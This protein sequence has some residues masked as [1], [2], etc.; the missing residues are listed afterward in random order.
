MRCSAAPLAH[1]HN[2][3]TATP[4]FHRGKESRL[5]KSSVSVLLWSRCNPFF[6]FFFFLVYAIGF[7]KFGV[8]FLL[9]FLALG[10]VI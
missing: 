7:F 10:F 8:F 4:L 1:V 6:L 3:V 2:L 5:S 9:P